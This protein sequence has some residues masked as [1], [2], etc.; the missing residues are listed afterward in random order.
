[1]C[2]APQHSNTSKEWLINNREEDEVKKHWDI[3]YSSRENDAKNHEYKKVEDIF[4][5]WPILTESIG[6]DLVS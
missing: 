1:M 2:E 4:V 5:Q 6:V 3:T